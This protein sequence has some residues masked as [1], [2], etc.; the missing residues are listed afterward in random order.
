MNFFR[1]TRLEKKLLSLEIENKILRA[2]YLDNL[3]KKDGTAD[4]G[5]LPFNGQKNR[6]KILT[7]I[8][9]KFS[10]DVILE[11]GTYLGNTTLFLST[12]APYIKT[13][14]LNSLLYQNAQNKFKD[15]SKIEV[16]NLDSREFLRAQVPTLKT[17]KVFCYL[18]AHWYDDLPLQFELKLL[19][20]IND[21]IAVIDDFEVPGD[22]G[23]GYDRYGK[24]K[25]NFDL[26]SEEVIKGSWKVQ[27]PAGQSKTETGS[28]RGW[29]ML[30]KGTYAEQST[31]K[32]LDCS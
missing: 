25:L 13:C 22:P 27:Y 28:K 21:V 3:E 11:T 12:F 24:K 9:E 5:L 19:R 32:A 2:L 4:F 8:L 15:F 31:D 26:I 17:K 6:K 18:D 14:E 23:L 1:N 16:F 29:V 10:P 30:S 7:P 20:T